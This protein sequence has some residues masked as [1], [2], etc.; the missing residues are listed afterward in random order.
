MFNFKN[1]LLILLIFFFNFPSNATI[2]I[3]YKIGEEII[4][5]IDIINEKK[6]LIFLR[7]NL[8]NLTEEEIIKISENSL[9][10]EIIK[11]K[12]IDKIF[13]N[14]ENPNFINQIKN[15]LF[16]FKNVKSEDE[17]VVLLKKNDIKY[18]K[19]IDKIKYEGLWNELIFN[20]Y[21]SLIKIDKGKLKKELIDK[22]SKNKKYE[23]NLSEIVFE[24]NKD[25]TLELKKNIILKYIKSNDF[26]AA[27]S[28]YSISSSSNI[29]GEIGWIKETLLSVNLLKIIKGLKIG[30]ISEPLKYPN[31][32]LL[33]KINDKKEMKQIV[34]IE[35]ELDELVKF[36]KNRQLNQVSLLFF[37]KLKQNI[38]IN[39][40]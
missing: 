9:I 28:K 35:K 17:F 21:N 15:N 22:L 20:K 18:E 3:K 11:K 34:S 4:T 7:P 19:I 10:R 33:L 26:K 37:K 25:E 36:E 40:N 13:N 23:F 16:K 12:E 2:K 27:A 8:K 1:L 24:T 29:G 38:I 14:I 31:G 39:E 5:N 6:Y 30:Q 32:Y